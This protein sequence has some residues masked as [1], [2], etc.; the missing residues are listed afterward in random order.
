MSNPWFRLYSEI[1][2]DE[3]LLMLAFQDRWHY[4]AILCLKNKGLIDDEQDESKLLRKVAVKL[5]LSN[6]EA[7]ELKRRLIEED[8]IDPEW[9]PKGWET[10]QYKKDDPAYQAQ[11]Q[12]KYRERKALKD[13]ENSNSV[14]A[15]LPSVTPPDTDTDT[16]TKKKKRHENKFSDDDYATAK[17][18]FRLIRNINPD[19]K[20]PDLKNWANTIRLMVEIDKRTHE[21]I[22]KLYKLVNANDFW[23]KNI[24]SPKTLRDKWDRMVITFANEK[25]HFQKTQEKQIS[26]LKE[27]VA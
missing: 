10:R 21:Q 11:K 26:G 24:L 16:D 9:Q 8:L 2:D 12:K 17:E 20:E 14:T 15:V 7:E 5:G 25:P 27:Y 1:I 23:Q 4:I 19:H 3:K 22:I 6:S 13:N 18:I